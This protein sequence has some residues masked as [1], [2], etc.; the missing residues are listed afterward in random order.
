M[1]LGQRT[2]RFVMKED[3]TP[4]NLEDSFRLLDQAISI[5]KYLDRTLTETDKVVNSL[6][7]Q[8]SELETRVSALE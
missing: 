8:V 6:S 1:E 7:S 4:K 2:N 5:I 3:I